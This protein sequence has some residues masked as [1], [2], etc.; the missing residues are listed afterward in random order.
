MNPLFRIIRGVCKPVLWRLIF[1]TLPRA[2]WR[3][4]FTQFNSF[5]TGVTGKS[6]N[7]FDNNPDV[8]IIPKYTELSKAKKASSRLAYKPRFAIMINGEPTERALF[9]IDR[10]VYENYVIGGGDTCDWALEIDGG[11]VL[12]R[13]ALFEA[14]LEL[15]VAL[16]DGDKP[17]ELTFGWRNA[18]GGGFTFEPAKSKFVSLKGGRGTRH[19]NRI[20][21]ACP[22]GMRL[23]R[24]DTF[25]VGH[26]MFGMPWID[27]SLIKKI[28]VF[29]LDML[30]DA[31]MVLPGVQKI[32]SLFPNLTL[33]VCTSKSNSVFWK[34]Q[35][36][37]NSVFAVSPNNKVRGLFDETELTDI[38]AKLK[39][40]NYDLAISL[41]I[42]A[43][44]SE[45]AEDIGDF[46]L[47]LSSA[48]NFTHNYPNP[49]IFISGFTFENSL[50]YTEYV[51]N[52]LSVFDN[53]TDIE[54]RAYI[55]D[56]TEKDISHFCETNSAFSAK[57]TVGF[58][59]GAGDS[60]R[61]WKTEKF[62]ELADMLI[63]KFSAVIVLVGGKEDA[64]NN[65]AMIALVKNRANILSV[66][67]KFSI[68]ESLALMKHFDVFVG[69][70]SGCGHMAALQ[71][72]PALTVCGGVTPLSL[73]APGGNSAIQVA[74]PNKHMLDGRYAM[75]HGI[76]GDITTDDVFVGFKKL[77]CVS[78]LAKKFLPEESE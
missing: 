65:D 30:G 60:F 76:M 16:L 49:V 63:E 50:H 70:D 57:R 38:L 10:Q 23:A 26:Y 67:G 51:L 3:A 72:V 52:M 8:F 59:I 45:F 15:N 25:P 24:P 9:R 41:N 1:I 58:H 39:E 69:N 2:I 61:Q 42:Q 29:Q 34:S 64:E 74:H 13:N 27:K 66:A 28:I 44:L 6:D 40:R 56:S 22:G 75:T 33:D 12:E 32:Q 47:G 11:D 73:I 78:G 48:N 43:S 14:A 20:L 54:R 21:V 77:L 5:L 7:F 18:E 68:P 36:N 71:G 4:G 31:M 17:A 62:A 46:T 35:P 19:I 37:I 55:S 53:S